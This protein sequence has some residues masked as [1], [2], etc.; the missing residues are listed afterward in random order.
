VVPNEEYLTRTGRTYDVTGIPPDVRVPVFTPE[1]YAAD[2]D[3]AFDAALHL[4][5][6]R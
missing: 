6:P 4:L 5:T 3:S 1:E 2:R